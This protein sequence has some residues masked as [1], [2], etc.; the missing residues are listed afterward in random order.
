MAFFRF[1][2]CKEREEYLFNR[3]RWKTENKLWLISCPAQF[4][5][6]NVSH[7]DASIISNQYKWFNIYTQESSSKEAHH[8]EINYY[9]CAEQRNIILTSTTAF[10]LSKETHHVEIQISVWFSP[11]IIVRQL[12]L[13]CKGMKQNNN[14][15]SNNEIKYFLLYNTVIF[16]SFIFFSCQLLYQCADSWMWNLW[17]EFIFCLS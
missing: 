7:T 3:N 15:C 4:I 12:I 6:S 17:A 16:V 5:L 11:G 9:L 13:T 14:Q 8:T 1:T 10:V 2:V